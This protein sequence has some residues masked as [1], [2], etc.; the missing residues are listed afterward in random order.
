VKR[1]AAGLLLLAFPLSACG[2]LVPTKSTAPS[3]SSSATITP[4]PG[5]TRVA[6]TAP[7]ELLPPMSGMPTDVNTVQISCS[8]PIGPSDSVAIVQL[9]TG[10]LVL[11][12]YADP[13]HPRSVCQFAGQPA[14][15]EQLVDAHHVV[16]SGS[17]TY[18][19]GSSKPVTLFAVVDLPQVHYH[20]FQLPTIQ[21]SFSTLLAVSP[22][23]DEVA[24]LSST[25][26][27]NRIESVDE[28]HL[29]RS[30]GDQVV[31]SIRAAYG[32]CGSPDDSRLADYTHA[33]AHLYVLDQSVPWLNT[34]VVLQGT[35]IQFQVSPPA[36]SSNQPGWQRGIQPEMA[37]WSPISETLYYRQNGEVWKWTPAGRQDFLPGINWYYP[38]ISA[39]GSHLA[40][41]TLRADGLHNVYVVDLAHNGNPKLIG[42]GARNLP[43]FLNSAQL[44]YK[45]EAQGICGAGGSQPLIYDLGDG[46][47]SP[48]IIDQVVAVWPSTSSNF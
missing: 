13:T 26:A 1:I 34:L 12:D 8:G 22:N 40:Y 31:A 41:S 16:V 21:D 35:E 44:W 23:L 9:H 39:D 10:A 17:A 15:I 46:S 14:Q 24:W 7:F 6:S 30:S 2:S 32:R 47:E 48:S 20:W 29:S 4:S 28:V 25:L 36:G 45:S 19:S 38:T 37:V 33:G 18:A 3:A 42:N 43:V 5:S 11:R 27:A